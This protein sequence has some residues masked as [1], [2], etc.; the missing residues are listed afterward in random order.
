MEPDV[1]FLEFIKGLVR[2]VVCW[3]GKTLAFSLFQGKL[4]PKVV[5][6]G[7]DCVFVLLINAHLP[8]P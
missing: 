4:N 3:N 1:M 6:S 7:E 8:I 5:V 2:T